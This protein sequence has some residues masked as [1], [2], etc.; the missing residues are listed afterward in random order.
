MKNSVLKKILGCDIINLSK[1]KEK[2]MEVILSVINVVGVIGAVIISAVTLFSTKN[3]QKM[4]QKVNIMATKRSERIDLMREYSSGVIT[5]AKKIF[6]GI[7]E[8]GT[9]GQL[10]EMGDKFISLLQYEYLHDIE[11][12]DSVNKIV[13]ICVEKTVDYKLLKKEINNF[14]KMCDIYVGVE[15]E[16]LKIESKGSFNGSGEVESEFNTFE[17]IYKKLLAEQKIED[18]ED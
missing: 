8:D 10:V 15:Y 1:Q 14:W 6:Y 9:K 3:L 5:N 18:I 4:E 7:A 13:K 12:I 17:S 11:L 16:R 2:F